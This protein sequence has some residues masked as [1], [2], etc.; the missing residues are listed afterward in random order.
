MLIKVNFEDVPIQYSKIL[1]GVGF[2]YMC[3][4]EWVCVRVVSVCVVLCFKKKDYIPHNWPLG[5]PIE[6]NDIFSFL[7]R[8]TDHALYAVHYQY[9]RKNWNILIEIEIDKTGSL[10]A[11]TLPPLWK[12]YIV[13]PKFEYLWLYTNISWKVIRTSKFN[14]SKPN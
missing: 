14:L 8:S 5:T 7:K 2:A 6:N 9:L 3:S 13:T 1:I 12:Q 11:K 10:S 4:Y